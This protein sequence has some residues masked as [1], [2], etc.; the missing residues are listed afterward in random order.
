MYCT[1]CSKNFLFLAAGQR[2]AEGWNKEGKSLNLIFFSLILPLF[3][4]LKTELDVTNFQ[5]TIFT[6]KINFGTFASE[7]LE[8]LESGVEV[9]SN[10]R[11]ICW[12]NTE[13]NHGVI[14]GRS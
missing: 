7:I 14:F 5:Q 6:L 11:H 2:V 8:R 10:F 1:S 13:S 3:Q 12:F 4:F 9:I